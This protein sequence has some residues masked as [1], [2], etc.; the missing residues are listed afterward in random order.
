[1]EILLRFLNVLLPILY[2]VV[3]FY[4]AR[5]F[6]H[7]DKKAEKNIPYV[8]NTTLILHALYIFLRGWS[9]NHYPLASIP[10][11]ATA[12]SFFVTAIYKYIEFRLR[13]KTSGYFVL[14]LA[15][16]L[17]FFS[18]L[19]IKNIEHI[20]EI[21]K[22]PI[23]DLHST[24]A[25]L[26]YTAFILSALYSIMYVLLYHDIK[27]NKF[28]IIYERLSSLETLSGMI[29]KTSVLGIL[30]LSL[31]VIFGHVYLKMKFDTLF[32]FDLKIFSVYVTWLVYFFIIL[33]RKKLNWPPRA[34]AYLSI[35]G[36]IFI[37][38]SILIVNLFLPT[39]HKF[40]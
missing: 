9:Q 5:F 30:F 24:F 3:T 7:N 10:E 11:I 21:L 20:P 23:F 27:S 18:S 26:G 2:F 1:M 8:L 39:F 4:Y 29:F 6:F 32:K 28:S 14:V 16:F 31:A 37:I 17:Q 40:Y 22:S 15:F 12:I 34:M 33:G 35:G 38:F 13:V 25:A 19:F 36:L